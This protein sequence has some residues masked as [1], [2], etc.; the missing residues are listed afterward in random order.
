MRRILKKK[1]SD[2]FFC[3]NNDGTYREV[4]SDILK[5]WHVDDGEIFYVNE[6][7]KNSAIDV[8]NMFNEYVC[9]NKHVVYTKKTDFFVTQDLQDNNDD[10]SDEE[11]FTRANS[12]DSVAQDFHQAA[13]DFENWQPTSNKEKSFKH[14]IKKIESRELKKQKL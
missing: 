7:E 2:V 1:D 9:K 14:M 5:L 4:Y 6:D 10:E 13:T 11:V 8:T 3:E 12:E